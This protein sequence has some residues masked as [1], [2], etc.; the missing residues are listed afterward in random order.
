MYHILNYASSNPH[1]T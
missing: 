1:L